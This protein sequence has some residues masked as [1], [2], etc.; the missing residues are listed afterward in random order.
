MQCRKELV[1]SLLHGAISNDYDRVT[2]NPDFKVTF[3]DAEYL[4]IRNGTRYIVT[5]EYTYT[6]PNQGIILN[7]LE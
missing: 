7:E 3:F 5:M 4:R 6:C 2:S 1:C